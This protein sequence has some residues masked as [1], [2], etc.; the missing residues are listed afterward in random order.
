MSIFR[1]K[2]FIIILLFLAFLFFISKVDFTVELFQAYFEENLFLAIV[3]ILILYAIKSI[4]MTIPNSVLYIASGIILPLGPAIIVNYMGLSIS[5][6]IGYVVGGKFET[7]KLFQIIESKKHLKRLSEKYKDNLLIYCFVIRLFGLPFGFVSFFFGS[8]K[9]PYFKY[10]ISSLL[11]VT[12]VM[13][14]I[15]ISGSAVLSSDSLEFV[16]PFTISL[17]VG[18]VVILFLSKRSAKAIS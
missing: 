11:G 9:M 18:F 14:P 16:F 10:H 13:I 17:F 12:P 8:Q 4:T 2:Y 3:V 15:I 6:L 5:L 1:K 7:G